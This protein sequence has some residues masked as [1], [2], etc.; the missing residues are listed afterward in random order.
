MARAYHCRPSELLGV[1]EP[2]EAYC[3]DEALYLWG[4]Y[5]ENTVAQ[6]GT[7]IN[8]KRMR[9]VTKDRM[10]SSLLAEPDAPVK[11]GTFRDPAD[12][13]K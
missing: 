13:L 10:L 11:A 9:Q 2:Y 5:I 12:L 4:S 1:Q 7:N 8:D 3:L 6:A